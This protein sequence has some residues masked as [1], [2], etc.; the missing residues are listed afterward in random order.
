VLVQVP[1][2]GYLPS[3]ACADC[4]TPARCPHCSGPLQLAGARDVP[5]CRWCGRV[6]ADY[7][8]PQCRGRRLRASVT[9]ARRTAEELGRAFPG[10]PVRT[11]GRDEILDA[12]PAGAAVVVATP[13]AEPV[14]EDGYGAVLL[15]DTWA[16]LTR[17]DLRAAEEAMRRWFTA[18]ALARPARRGG[19]VVVV[20][21]GSLATV[22][23]L[24]RWD[25]GWFAA[26]E[27]A[28]RRELGFPPAARM[29]SL[30]GAPEAVAELL[31]AAKLPES[32]ELLGPVPAEDEQERMLVRTSRSQALAMAAALHEGAAVRSAKKAAL[33]VRIE[34]D[35]ATLF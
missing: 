17:S 10:V 11:S 15:L 35:P 22:Q 2:R 12:V 27:L 19:K 16:L 8:C 28:E 30:T 33:P 18:S 20:A 31:D 13:G 25:P 1:R 34:V 4:R 24:I 6:A 5:T 21:D 29:A 32:A 9:G 23:A 14:A 7:S 3:I 26:R